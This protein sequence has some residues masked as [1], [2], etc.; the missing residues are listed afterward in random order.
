MDSASLNDFPQQ[1]E[2]LATC[3][4]SG[5]EKGGGSAY[6]RTKTVERRTRRRIVTKNEQKE[7]RIPSDAEAG[8]DWDAYGMS[9]L[10]LFPFAPG[11][12]WSRRE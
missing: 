2:P 5:R 9:E 4:A 3:V 11:G 8:I 7:G 10:L 12:S 6:A 1:T